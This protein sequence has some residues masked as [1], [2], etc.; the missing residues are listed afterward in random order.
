MPQHLD[1]VLPLLSQCVSA[2]DAMPL[3]AALTSAF[4]DLAEHSPEATRP[5]LVAQRSAL[6]KAR[7]SA[8]LRVAAAR[9]LREL[10]Q[11]AEPE[12]AEPKAPAPSREDRRRARAAR[13][14]ARALETHRSAPLPPAQQPVE[15][16]SGIGGTIGQSL[17]ARGIATLSDLIWLLPLAYEDERNVTPMTSLQPGTRQV[18]EGT[19]VRSSGGGRGRGRPAEVV[20]EGEGPTPGRVGVL[21]L[22][23][24]RAPPGLLARFPAGA[25]YRVSGVIEQFRAQLQITH[26]ETQRLGDGES[27][28][29]RGIVPRYPVVAGVPPRKLAATIK[30]AVGR[31]VHDLDEAVPE[32]VRREQNMST[33]AAALRALHE[34]PAELSDDELARWNEARTEHHTRLAFEEFFLLELALF[35]RRITEQ[36][37]VAEPLVPPTSARPGHRAPL[38]RVHDA[39]GFELTDAQRRVSREIFTDLAQERPMRRLLQGDVGCG[40][41]AV[42]MLAAAQCIAAGAQVAFMAPTEVLAEQHFRSL[43]PLSQALGVRAALM[44]GS[45]RESHRK[46]ARKALLEGKIDL[47]VGT[48]ALLSEGVRFARLRLAIIDEQHRFGVGQRLRLLDKTDNRVAPHLLVMTA[49]PIPRTLT[50][51]L[52]GDLSASVIDQMPAG[53]VPPVTRE[54]PLAER[55]RALTQVTRALEAGGQAF[56]V[57]PTIEENEENLLSAVE[58]TFAE[59]EP[60][61]S[62]FGVALLHGRLPPA[63]KQAAMEKFASGQVRVLVS[64]TIVEVGIDVPRANVILIENAERFGLAQLHQLRGRVGRSGQRSACLL[65]HQAV[66]EEARA[67]MRVMCETSDGFKIAEED[68]RLRGPGEIFGHRQ[69]GLPGFRFGDLRRDAPLLAAAREAANRVIEADPELTSDELAGARRVLDRSSE[70]I[71]R[72]VKEEAG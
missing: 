63:Q 10:V 36:G 62:Q 49:T 22:V 71:R 25:R 48:H 57:C 55:E 59:L 7:S 41:T 23:W 42:A 24:F 61:F 8:E 34:P 11:N 28:A 64:T 47:V 3:Q 43:G 40:K 4:A 72:V 58:K 68:L 65:V 45:E 60:R 52:Y 31:A 50:L 5:Q 18:T 54:Y 69:S 46:K 32:S 13:T 38:D 44:L 6:A 19:V 35:R 27:A 67:R 51:A 15:T 26:P 30:Q 9:L 17:R 1:T 21:R 56:V 16:L 2:Q 66:G 70:G 39:F 12:E 53:R 20:L 33:L 29:A 37:V 14:Q